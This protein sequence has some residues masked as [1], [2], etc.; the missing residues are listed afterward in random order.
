MKHFGLTV[1]SLLALLPSTV[2]AALVTEVSGKGISSGGADELQSKDKRYVILASVDGK[3]ELQA[4]MEVPGAVQAADLLALTFKATMMSSVNG[5]RVDLQLY[6][7]QTRRWNTQKTVSAAKMGLEFTF[8]TN[9]I[10]AFVVGK[11]QKL[12]FRLAAASS[13]EFKLAV[14]RISFS[15]KGK[16]LPPG[17]AGTG[18]GIMSTG[19]RP[20]SASSKKSETSDATRSAAVDKIK[21][22]WSFEKKAYVPKKRSITRRQGESR[23]AY[24]R[25]KSKEEKRYREAMSR[26]K[27]AE[28][29]DDRLGFG[30]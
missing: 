13:Q 7:W 5:V 29:G 15:G 26:A 19:A 10:D 21:G 23:E 2:T 14:D 18:A 27:R 22:S 1:L 24:N 6:N 8:T 3:A 30:D 16:P 28:K 20:T 17:V 4:G 9:D 25:R 12:R 11:E